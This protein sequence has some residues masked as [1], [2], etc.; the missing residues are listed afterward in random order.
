MADRLAEMTTDIVSHYVASNHISA[1]QLPDLIRSVYAGLSAIEAPTAVVATT[2]AATRPTPARIRRSVT[3][4]ALISFEDGK[5][6]KT[7]KRHLNTLGLTFAE[8][9]AKWGLPSDYPSAAPNYSAMRSEIARASSFGR[10]TAKAPSAPAE[11]TAPAAKRR[12]RPAKP[13][14]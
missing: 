12:G 11:I 7:L 3:P 1:F 4:D 8:Y 14:A 13:K 6:H 5:P 2:E 10:R 9:K